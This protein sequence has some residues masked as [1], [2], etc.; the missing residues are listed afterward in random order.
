[1]SPSD[2]DSDSL[3]NPDGLWADPVLRAKGC[4]DGETFVTRVFP[5]A[6]HSG[7][8]WAERLHAPLSFLLQ[9]PKAPAR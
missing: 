9:V 7:R 6:E 5:G 2:L 4:R 1:M 8:P 3:R